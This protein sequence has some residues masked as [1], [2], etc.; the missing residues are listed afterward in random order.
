MENLAYAATATNTQ[1]DTL[2]KMNAKS[3]EQLKKALDTIKKLTEDNSKLLAIVEKS[4]LCA[5]ATP[6]TPTT[7]TTT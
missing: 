4:V 6:G 5:L 1:I 7:T 2:T 3:T